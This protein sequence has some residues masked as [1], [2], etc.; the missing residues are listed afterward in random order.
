MNRKSGLAR[1]FVMA[2]VAAAS[3]PAVA[4]AQEEDERE[5]GWLYS[6]ELSAVWTGG[7]AS[8]RTLGFGGTVRGVWET[9]ELI[10]RGSGLTAH[11]GTI[12]RVAVGTVDVFDVDKN[13]ETVKTAE[14]WLLNGRYESQLGDY[15]FWFVGAGWERNTFAGFNSR[16]SAVGGAGNTWL[17]DDFT[18][19]KTTYGLTFTTQDDVIEDPSTPDS[20][21]GFRLGAELT[22]QITETTEW[23][24]VAALDENFA[25]FED[26][27]IDW[28]NSLIIDISA[29]LSFK[30]SLRLLYDN[31]P[32]LTEVPLEQPLGTPTGQL[33]LAPLSKLDTQFTIALV[34]NF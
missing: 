20:F 1:V 5:L 15:F 10:I 26:L 23:E 9:S 12:T 13:T 16:V 17:E 11:T 34:A 32:S 4:A 3:L 24:S 30:T 21:V 14:N 8:A 2:L 6:A 33:V 19:F 22:Q 25:E 29:V 28:V 31:L 18:L 27:R 7:N